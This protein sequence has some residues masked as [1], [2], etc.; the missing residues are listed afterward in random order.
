[1]GTISHREGTGDTSY[2]S[3]TRNIS[4]ILNWD[5][6]CH[7]T[8]GRGQGTLDTSQWLTTLVL[9]YTETMSAI[10]HCEGTG[11]TSYH[12]MAHN[13]S[14]ILHWDHGC[15]I[16]LG[17]GQG[18]LVTSQWLTTLVLYYT[19]TMGAISHREGTG[20]TSYH[21]MTR[22]ISAILNWD[23][24]C[25]ITLGRGQGTLVT[26][27]WLTTLVLYYTETM[28]AISHREG[29]GDTSYIS[30]THNI[31]AILHWDHG[32][33]ITLGGDRGH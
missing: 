4:A 5:H 9:Y 24:G 26:S 29:T 15:H 14:A 2:H 20:D 21:S 28:G 23:H 13:I 30:M 8:L 1:M 31:S 11:D 19:E 22:N 16:T 10:S 12:S 27:Q 17:R 25:H 7:I 33:H 3:M 18:T 32:C 6:G